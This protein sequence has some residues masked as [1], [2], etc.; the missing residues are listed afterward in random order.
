MKNT[1]K[2]KEWF[3]KER[4][5]TAA[6]NV[7]LEKFIRETAEKALWFAYKLSGNTEAARELVQEA[8]YRVLRAWDS[9]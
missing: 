3:G 5:D 6:R 2:S 4:M 8:S 1:A 7:I 9:A